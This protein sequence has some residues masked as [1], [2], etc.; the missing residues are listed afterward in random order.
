MSHDPGRDAASYVSG[1]MRRRRARRFEEHILTCD[2]CWT[3]VKESR[4]GRRL[5]EADRVLAPQELR[6]RVRA[7]IAAAEPSRARRTAVGVLDRRPP[8]A[9][10]SSAWPVVVTVVPLIV[11]A[12][13]LVTLSGDDS[14]PPPIAAAITD[15]QTQR[16][17]ADPHVP[18]GD[19][20]DLSTLNLTLASSGT[21]TLD[22]LVVR[23][24]WYAD[25][26]GRRVLIYTSEAAFPIAHGAWWDRPGGPWRARVGG[27]E[28]ICSTRPRPMLA[29]S[30]DDGLLDQI[31]RIL[32]LQGP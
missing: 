10:R 18:D 13:L 3:E 11:G 4:L 17:A 19:A 9:R 5:G 16:I 12:V 30:D 6:E 29:L 23:S 22:G 27:V 14:Q 8:R 25:G 26:A 15:F 2:D 21:G 32:G 24:Y 1:V 20:P 7:A 31:A 28:I